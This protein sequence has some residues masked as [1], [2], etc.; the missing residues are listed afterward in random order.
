MQYAITLLTTFAFALL[1]LVSP[2]AAMRLTEMSAQRSPVHEVPTEP[3]RAV[4]SISDAPSLPR[5][6]D[7]PPALV[8]PYVVWGDLGDGCLDMDA[9]ARLM[10]AHNSYRASAPRPDSEVLAR[11]LAGLERL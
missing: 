11:A 10:A 9:A 7:N 8:R 5:R 1:A 4:D 6:S 2:S 3:F